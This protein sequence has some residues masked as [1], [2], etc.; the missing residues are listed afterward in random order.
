[1]KLL[2]PRCA[3]DAMQAVMINTAGGI[4]GGDRFRVEARAEAGATLTLTTQAAE[5]AYRAQPNETGRLATRLHVE[6]GARLNWLPQETILFQGSTL[7][8][9]LHVTLSGSARLLLCE[10]LIFGR[11][12]MGEV[13]TDARFSARIEITRDG[14]PLY[15]DSL[16]L[17]GDVAAHM[18]RPHIAAGARAMATLIHVNPD[19]ESHLDAIRALLPATGGASLLFPDVLVLRLL[20]A[21]GF[22]L[23]QSLVP[24]LTRLSGAALPRPWMI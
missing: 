18:A 8:R 12:A 6:D 24:I 7:S 15:L 17:S 2:F 3:P 10:P 19:A 4:T 16:T 13:L 9:R 20:A 1:M 21:D 22:D 5:R 14:A 23:R 11:A